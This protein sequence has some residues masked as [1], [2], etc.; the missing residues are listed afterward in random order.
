MAGVVRD[1]CQRE[2]LYCP[3]FSIGSDMAYKYEK[4]VP[5]G[6][7]FDEYQRMFHLTGEDLGQSILGCADGPASFNAGMTRQKRR[8]VS[9][10]PLYEFTAAQIKQRIDATYDD[11][12]EQ[13]RHNKDKF[14]WNLVTSL[15][16]LGRLRLEAMHDFLAD[17]EAGKKERR[18]VP[19]ALPDLPFAASTFDL[20]LCSHF[21]FFYSDSLSHEFH[22]QA[23][24]ELCRVALEVRIF[25]M[26]TY[27]AERS[28]LVEPIVDHLNKAG[29]VVSIEEV[30]YEFQR[31]GNMMMKV[32]S[33]TGW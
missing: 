10:D 22:Q 24:D 20:A 32:T 4:A 25:P 13:T 27:N 29:R 17:Y 8:V 1:G 11:V 26:L 15:D 3:F 2:L 18:Y 9:C 6:R 31:G 14:V 5:W 33:R 16:E 12:M 28:A 21:L 7:S 19:A 30:P 23:V